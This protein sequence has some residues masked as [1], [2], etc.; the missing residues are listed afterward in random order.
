MP[1]A[2][3]SLLAGAGAGPAVAGFFAAPWPWGLLAI[4]ALAGW[5]WLVSP[6]GGRGVLFW[7]VGC[8]AVVLGIAVGFMLGAVG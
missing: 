1:R 8:V 2:R 5:V 4:P 3:D 7:V 6:R